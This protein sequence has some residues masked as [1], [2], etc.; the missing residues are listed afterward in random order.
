MLKR[1]A[2]LV[3]GSN[4]Y[5]K[6]KDLHLQDQLRF[7]FKSFLKILTGNNNLV[8][9]T[10]YVGSVKTGSDKLMD[11]QHRKQQTLLSHLKNNG[12]RYS[13]GYLMKSKGRFHEKGVDVQMAVD[14]LINSYED[15]V[16]EIILISS[17]TDLI[18]AIKQ[19]IKLGKE[20]EYIGFSHKPSMALKSIC[21]RTKLLFRNDLERLLKIH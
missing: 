15:L 7:D 5:Y 16:D 1:V 12:I 14:I 17:D 6:L 8:S 11:K 2:L 3:D 9:A 10:Y 18:P 19:A 21:T 20:V 13:L 4:F